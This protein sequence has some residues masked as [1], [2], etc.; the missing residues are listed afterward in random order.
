MKL[1]K[2]L[3]ISLLVASSVS[4]GG[5]SH[6]DFIA[7]QFVTISLGTFGANRRIFQ[8]KIYSQGKKT[9]MEIDVAGRKS[10]NISRGDLTPPM[11]WTL[12][13]N[14]KMYM[15]SS[16]PGGGG[17]LSAESRKD[18]EK[19]F[20]TKEPVAGVMT[21]KFRLVWKDK[22]GNRKTGLAWEAIDMDN[23][24]M[25]QEFFNKDE[26]VLVQL[27]NIK[28]QKLDPTLFEIPDDYKKITMPES[29]KK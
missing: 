5:V 4:L 13:P 27:A 10:V 7:D 15:E 9:R 29:L 12:M 24:P 17:P 26:H 11:F 2:I 25:R 18:Y 23:A 8:S 16:G 6:A 22:D 3:L 1:C 28:V 21:N 19:V 20:L 14:E